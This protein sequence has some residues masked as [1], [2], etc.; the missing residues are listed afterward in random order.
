VRRF[1]RLLNKFF[2][3]PVFRL[4]LGPLFGNPVTGYVM[5]LRTVGSKTGR[6]R[7]APVTYAIA[8]GSVYCLAGWGRDTG[9]YRNAMTTPDIG[10][11]LPGGAIAGHVEE[12]EDPDER[13]IVTRQIFKNAGLMGFTEGFDPF[14]ASDDTI[15]SKTIDMPVVRIRPTGIAAG[16]SDPG[17][18]AWVW[19]PILTLV[20]VAV[21]VA[22]VR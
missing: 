8:D 5:V 3:V 1:F 19:G 14:R 22:I 20:V 15:R 16:V 9:W 10:V 13:L 7:Y 6:T 4:G 11:L 21:I 17:G 2:I 12:V 18:W